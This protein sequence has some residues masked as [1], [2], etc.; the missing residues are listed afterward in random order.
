MRQ[1]WSDTLIKDHLV[2][3]SLHHVYLYFGINKKV[4]LYRQC[5]NFHCT[6]MY[7]SLAIHIYGQ[8]PPPIHTYSPTPGPTTPYLFGITSSTSKVITA[9][10]N[11]TS[12]MVQAIWCRKNI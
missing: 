4:N 10:S 5:K 8:Q 3:L 1:Y 9:T 2:Q 6:G 12:N 7:F 11:V